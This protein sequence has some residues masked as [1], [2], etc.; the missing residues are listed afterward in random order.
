[1]AL[2]WQVRGTPVIRAPITDGSPVSWWPNLPGNDVDEWVH[3]LG[4]VWA[5]SELAEAIRHA[6]PDLAAGV[7]DL[8][9]RAPD[10]IRV[11]RARKVTAAVVRYVLRARHR[12]NPVRPLCGHR[13]G[14]LR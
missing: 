6:S 10:G 7:D 14:G 1:M 13:P 2:R 5:A 9:S 8:R 3:W 11:R 4:C 12:A